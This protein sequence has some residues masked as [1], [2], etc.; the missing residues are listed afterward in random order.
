MPI[1]AQRHHPIKAMLKALFGK[2]KYTEDTLANVF[3][4]S[5]IASVDE[6]FEDIALLIKNDPEFE[7]R[8]TF[9]NTDSDRFLLTVLVGNLNYLSRYFSAVEEEALKRSIIRKFA[10]VFGTTYEEFKEFVAEY[11][12]FM[13]RVNHPSKNILYGMSKTMFYKYN[14]SQFQDAY[15]RNMKVPSPILL[16]RMDDM[17][18]NYVWDW[19]AYLAK[20]KLQTSTV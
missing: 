12:N 7:T 16:K 17:M 8:P 3:V 9:S 15:F 2:K 13:W 11:E 4:N 5:I 19:D 6:G 14:L 20:I 1:F 18:E 10:V